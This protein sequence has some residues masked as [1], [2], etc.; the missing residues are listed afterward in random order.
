[1]LTFVP[2]AGAFTV[3]LLGGGAVVVAQV[4]PSLHGRP[5]RRLRTP[6]PW[7]FLLALVLV[8]AAGE[9]SLRLRGE[10]DLSFAPLLLLGAAL[11]PLAA[12]ALAASS[13]GEPP[14][15]R[16]M[17]LAA[18]AGGTLSVGAA[19]VLELV[20][21]VLAAVLIAPIRDMLRDLAVLIEE[22]RFSD[23]LRSPGALLILAQLAVVAPLVEEAV[24]P[25][26]VVIL[27]RRIRR[28]SDALL[29]GMAC[30]AGFAI[31]ENIM[32]EGGGLKLWTGVTI[33]RAVG[34]ALHPFGAG[35]VALGIVGVVHAEHDAWRRLARNY[36][37]AVGAHAIWNG[38]SGIFMLLESAHQGVLG[39]VDLRGVI[40]DAALLA[41]LLA[42]GVILMLGVREIASRLSAGQ[43]SIPAP[44]PARVLALWGI[45]CMGVLL[46]AAV[47]AGQTILKY[48]GSALVR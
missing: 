44:A 42:E 37:L 33:V 27:G 2:V 32:Y 30:G 4:R 46:P 38:V 21:P 5:S 15:Y 19:I 36:L 43:P 10:P 40:M 17:T 6:Y 24:K 9:A 8:V 28:A 45:A 26:G 14:S 34:G 1:V 41:L 11:P 48:L 47:A 25:I 20:V 16:R 3:A 13:V 35:L 39:P 7:T 31:I 22:Q 23:L 18:V 29:L 12:V